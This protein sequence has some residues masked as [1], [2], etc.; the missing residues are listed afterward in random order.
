L[1]CK[2]LPAP[3]GLCTVIVPPSA[4][5]DHVTA[6]QRRDRPLAAEAPR[7]AGNEPGL[8]GH[9]IS[10]WSPGFQPGGIAARRPAYRSP[11]RMRLAS[12]ARQAAD[13]NTA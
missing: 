12:S 8:H 3:T 1:A 9:E 11:S 6:V 10:F 13:R 5:G 7:R 4:S 2:D